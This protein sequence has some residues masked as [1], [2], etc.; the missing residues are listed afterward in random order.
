MMEFSKIHASEGWRTSG[1][2]G[3]GCDVDLNR[4][5]LVTGGSSLNGVMKILRNVKKNGLMMIT[6]SINLWV[7]MI[8]QLIEEKHKLLLLWI[9]EF[10]KD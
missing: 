5:T 3:T 10:E 6:E 7:V 8:D 2:R 1:R 9:A 4:V